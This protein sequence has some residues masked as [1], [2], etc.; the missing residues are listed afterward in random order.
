M[1]GNIGFESPSRLQPRYLPEGS[2]STS[3]YYE[4]NS[5]ANKSNSYNNDDASIT[6]AIMNM[7]RKGRKKQMMR[8]REYKKENPKVFLGTPTV[9]KGLLF[10]SF[11]AWTVHSYSETVNEKKQAVANFAA[12]SEE[13]RQQ[14]IDNYLTG[15]NL[16]KKKKEDQEI[17]VP[18]FA[19]TPTKISLHNPFLPIPDNIDEFFRDVNTP[20]RKTDV[21][22]F[23]HIHKSGG[24][25]MK[26]ILGECM[27]KVEAAEAGIKHGHIDDTE[28]KIVS[29]KSKIQY[30]NGMYSSEIN[31]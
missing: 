13:L 26:D 29:F 31:L 19:V 10:L 8:S 2:S 16:R 28:L 7:W 6:E 15:N 3:S 23:W 27:G 18:R 25:S 1:P 24:T 14:K 17:N 4:N 5:Q 9:A 12:I 22:L 21:P 30:V 11:I 20:R